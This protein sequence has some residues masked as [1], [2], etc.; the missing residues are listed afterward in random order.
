[1]RTHLEL[2]K[3]GTWV[4]SIKEKHRSPVDDHVLDVPQGEVVALPTWIVSTNFILDRSTNHA[5]VQK[6]LEVFDDDDEDKLEQDLIETI[7]NKP[8]ANTAGVKWFKQF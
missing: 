3:K 5:L 1:M 6:D 4:H 7:A 8:T 2:H